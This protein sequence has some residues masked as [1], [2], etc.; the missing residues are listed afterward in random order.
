MNN[1]ICSLVFIDR[2]R[3]LYTQK[4]VLQKNNFFFPSWADC[5]L[6]TVFIIWSNW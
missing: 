5:Y 4:N 3:V 2:A 6:S 1:E